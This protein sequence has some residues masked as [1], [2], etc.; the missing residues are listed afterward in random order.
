M[1]NIL[2]KITCIFI[3]IFIGTAFL[4]AEDD[5]NIPDSRGLSIEEFIK[6]A[7]ANDTVFEEILIDQLS[8]PYRK[9]LSLPAGDLI[10]SVRSQY[11]LILNQSRGE[12]DVGISLDKLFPFTGT[13]ISA[14]YKITPALSSDTNTSALTFLISQPIAENAFGHATRLKDKIIDVEVE[15]T[16]HQVVEAYEDYL[17]AVITAYYNWYSAYENLKIGESSYQQ[18]LKLLDNIRER[19]RNSI[20]LPIDVNK[21]NVQVLAKKENLIVLQEKYENMLNFIKQTIR[22]KGGEVLTPLDPLQYENRE[23]LFEGDYERFVK[24]SRTYDI[25]NFLETK[26]SLEVRRDADSLL[27]STNLLLGYKVQ[28]EQWRIKNEDDYIF[29]GVSIEWPLPGQ[30]ERAEYETSKILYHKTQLS[31]KNKYVQL[32]TD[33]RNIFAQIEREKELIALAEEKIAFAEAILEDETK[34][35][36]YGKV[37]LNDFIDAANRVDDS[38]FNK[39]LHFVQLKILTTEWLRLTD[40]LVLKKDIKWQE[41]KRI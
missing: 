36:A 34:N 23:I 39:I 6:L 8:L 25:L 14:E 32:D 15:V 38:R 18:N 3:V 10:L 30:V 33:L 5:K 4:F 26:S 31:N 40:Q 19:Q 13:N 28:G 29:A 17:A 11:D 2:K 12:P 27:P 21:I 16:R 37:S 1:K 35:Y 20:A 41:G 22:Y 9:D 7:V 24:T